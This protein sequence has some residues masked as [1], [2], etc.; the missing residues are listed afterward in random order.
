MKNS[1][2]KIDKPNINNSVQDKD[3][4]QNRV[5]A[6][7]KI[8]VRLQSIYTHHKKELVV[9]VLYILFLTFITWGFSKIGIDNIKEIISKGG[10]LSPILFIIF[11]ASTIIVAPFEG[12]FLMLASGTLFGYFWGVVYTIIAGF[13]G[14]SVNFWISRIYGIKIVEKLLGHKVIENINKLATRINEH[15]ILL[16]PL[17][18]TG[19]FDIVG[20]A[21]GLT[22]IEY[23]KFLIAVSFSSL[24]NV[25]IYVAVGR[26]LIEG[27]NTFVWL[28]VGIILAIVI[29]YLLKYLQKRFGFKV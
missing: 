26:G 15:P 1:S 12:S 21:A 9:I 20:Y 4:A 28:A 29:Y 14:S 25:P 3:L 2:K 8:A 24:I 27:D 5:L 13:L 19:L 6:S 23:K 17:M 16:I 10:L 22:K 7:D 11:H 18:A